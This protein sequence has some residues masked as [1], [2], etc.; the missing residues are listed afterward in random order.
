MGV[1]TSHLQAEH[2][3]IPLRIARGHFATNNCHV[4]YYLDMTYTKHRL[5]EAREAARELA[6]EYDKTK[7]VDTILC[8]EGTEVLGT[9][10]A[11]ELTA[12]GIEITNEHKTMY[13]V[14]PEITSGNQTIYRGNTIHLIRNRHV[15]ILAATVS[16]GALLLDAINSVRYYGGIPEG[17]CAVFSAGQKCG[18]LTITSIYGPHL[19]EDYMYV[20]A[21]EC[22]LCKAGVKLDALVNS[23]GISSL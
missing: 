21:A 9:C 14:T 10:L 23:Y 18:G 17:I 22:P 19:L 6:E 8:L 15:L 7:P 12:A 20:P 11:E 2:R 5:A 13:L 3:R 16:T 1:S 4:N